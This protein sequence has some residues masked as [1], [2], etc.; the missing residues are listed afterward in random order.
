MNESNG[1]PRFHRILNEMRDLHCKKSADYGQGQD[2]LANVKASAEFGVPAWVGTMIRANDKV[3]RIK[4][5]AVKGN[6]QNESLEDSF[7]DLASYAILALILYREQN[8]A[9]V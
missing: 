7:I 1:D 4:S 3:I 8:A 5:M 6:L 2:P 9:Q